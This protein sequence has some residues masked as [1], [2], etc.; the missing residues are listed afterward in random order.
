[1]HG[2]FA[3]A[4]R[5][6]LHR[7]ADGV[8]SDVWAAMKSSQFGYVVPA[9]CAATHTDL[10]NWNGR[11]QCEGV[12]RGRPSVSRHDDRSTR[13]GHE[14]SILDH[15]RDQNTVFGSPHADAGAPLHDDR[16]LLPWGARVTS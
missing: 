2:F 14:G 1:M 6:N 10:K 7:I 13:R 16:V 8:L 11:E 15:S 5:N 9:A 12:R 4:L 3:F